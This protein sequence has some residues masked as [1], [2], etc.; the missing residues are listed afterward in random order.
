MSWLLLL[1]AVMVAGCASGVHS[2]PPSAQPSTSAS[3]PVLAQ[4]PV[5][6]TNYAIGTDATVPAGFR[7]V[8]GDVA[9]QVTDVG[10][11]EPAGSGETWPYFAKRGLLI[12][13]GIGPISVSV[14]KSWRR[15][16]AIEWG[17]GPSSTLTLSACGSPPGVWDAFAGG[18]YLRTRIACVPVQFRVGK[19]TATVTYD[20]GRQCGRRASQQV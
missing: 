19:R 16:A 10:E 14:P 8:L 4:S 13:A 9:T 17:T 20:I 15:R 18:L 11:G 5:C 12:P 2:A 3:E 1:C 6:A 7:V